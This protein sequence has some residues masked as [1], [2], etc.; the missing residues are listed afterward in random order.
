MS[1]VYIYLVPILLVLFGVPGN[2]IGFIVFSRK[3]LAK[4]PARNI[5]RFM[6]IV[7]TIYLLSQIAQ[8][9]MN[10]IGF[11]LRLVSDI[12]CK[13]YKFYNFAF[14]PISFW[15]LVY[16]SIERFI[17]IRFRSVKF[18]QNG[19]I[20]FIIIAAITVYNICLY[21][22][23]LDYMQIFETNI[24]STNSSQIL[25]RCRLRVP[26]FSKV[27]S[28]MDLINAVILPFIFMAITSILLTV[29]ILASRLRILNFSSE[30]DRKKLAR[31]IKVGITCIILNIFFFFL[32]LPICI[33]NYMLLSDLD[34]D[35]YSL[36]I[37]IFYVNYFINFYILAFFNSAFRNELFIFFGLKKNNER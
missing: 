25:K 12:T 8:D 15:L 35:T 2:A 1:F 16:I 14:A 17:S 27:I 28:I 30:Q 13:L 22:P 4:F 33:A 21:S 34:E 24:N 3:K 5:Y 20:Q 26:S 37:A 32:N 6:A 18:F 36:V 7:D 10:Y 9:T 11:D 31:D 23:M 29:T 19:K